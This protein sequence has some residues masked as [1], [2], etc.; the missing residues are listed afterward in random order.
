MRVKLYVEGGERASVHIACREGF[1]K[2]LERAG[3]VGRM[4]A[5]KACGGRNAAF[6]DFRTAL[7]TAGAEEYPML[8]VDSEGPVSRPAWQHL[9]SADR[10]A[11][12][13]G[14][15]DM[16]AQLMVQCMETWC[17]ADRS[18]LRIFFAAC[19]QEGALPSLVDLEARAKDDVQ[20][21]LA[22]ATR[23]CGRGRAYTKGVRSFELL[24]R[25]DPDVLKQHLPHF[26]RLCR[27]IA[28]RL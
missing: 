4:P 24:G 11:R 6:D 15:Q 7:L 3:F 28:A 23:G 19:L 2:L 9:R 27:E 8:L 20:E 10:W 21:A 13:R 25:L 16:Q 18:A 5:I 26:A 1:R 22:N 17:V 12:P 14:A